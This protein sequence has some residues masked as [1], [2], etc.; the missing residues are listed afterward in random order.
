MI[1]EDEIIISIIDTNGNK[2]SQKSISYSF[3]KKTTDSQSISFKVI[4]GVSMLV[5][6]MIAGLIL[7]I[8]RFRHRELEDIDNKP[9]NGPPISGPPITTQNIAHNTS[10][11]ITAET[12]PPLPENGLPQ[13]WTM[14]QWK[15][16]GQQYL[17]MT[18][19][20]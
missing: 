16:Y 3:P 10:Q 15:Y 19:R 8:N 1:L 20:Q 14:E 6:I 7:T 11:D 2:L 12:S 4:G 13:G 18:N 17:E 9:I 5:L